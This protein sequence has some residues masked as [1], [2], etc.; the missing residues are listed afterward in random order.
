[1]GDLT[2]KDIKINCMKCQNWN[3]RKRENNRRCKIIEYT[4][5]RLCSRLKVWSYE[6]VIYPKNQALICKEIK[7]EKLP[8]SNFGISVAGWPSNFW[9]KFFF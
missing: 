4:K 7:K 9:F 5:N 8:E 1:M 6:K 3:I 2:T